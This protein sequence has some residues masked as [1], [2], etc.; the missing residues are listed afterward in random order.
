MENPLRPIIGTGSKTAL[1][2]GYLVGAALMIIGALVE[3]W[4][5]VDA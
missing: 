1:L 2:A 5:G 3:G 4:L